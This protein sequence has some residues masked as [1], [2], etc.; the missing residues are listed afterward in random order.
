MSFYNASG[1]QP[2][3]EPVFMTPSGKIQPVIKPSVRGA[4]ASTVNEVV[5]KI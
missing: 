1:P 4:T 3:L 2:I 5:E